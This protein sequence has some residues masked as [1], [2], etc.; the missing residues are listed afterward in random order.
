MSD[1]EEAVLA[2][3]RAI[4]AALE[5]TGRKTGEKVPIALRDY[6]PSFLA[7]WADYAC[8]RR[9]NKPE[10]WRQWARLLVPPSVVMES[11]A[12]YKAMPQWRDG[13]M[14]EPARWLKSEPWLDEPTQPTITVSPDDGWEVRRD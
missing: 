3:L 5:R 4:R 6:S 13:F 11:L 12:K 10:A 1:F 2:E 9:R 7:F 8:E 14:P